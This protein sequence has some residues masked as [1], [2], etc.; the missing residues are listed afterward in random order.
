M[1]P[2]NTTIPETREGFLD[3]A[4]ATASQVTESDIAAV[5]TRMAQLAKDESKKSDAYAT[6]FEAS[7][8]GLRR[9]LDEANAQ[10]TKVALNTMAVMEEKGLIDGG[11]DDY[12][13]RN[14][15]YY[16]LK[17]LPIMTLA[18]EY[19]I[20]SREGF[21]CVKDKIRQIVYEAFMKILEDKPNKQP[22]GLTDNN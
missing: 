1:N 16:M 13:R 5:L 12:V 2:M 20:D 15:V 6:M 8:K 3:E 22:E 14:R 10:M 11:R 9:L 18:L 7:H 17:L 19:D 21:V 4:V